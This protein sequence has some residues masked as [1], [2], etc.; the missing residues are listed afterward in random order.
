V[1]E[2][3]RAG[4]RKVRLMSVWVAIG[5]V[6]MAV[7]AFTSL[8]ISFLGAAVIASTPVF[9]TLRGALQSRQAPRRRVDAV[10]DVAP[11]APGRTRPRPPRAPRRLR[12]H[13]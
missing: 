13:E 5:I 12:D 8:W 10:P 3:D 4:A 2:R 11:Q 1:T 7:G 9:F 6:L